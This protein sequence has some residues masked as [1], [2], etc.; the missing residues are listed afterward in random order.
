MAYRYADTLERIREQTERYNR[1]DGSVRLIAVS[2]QH[3]AE[4]VAAVARLGQTDFGENYVQES[5]AKIRA[6]AAML[7]SDSSP[8]PLVWHFIGHI[9]SRKCRDIAETFDWVHTIDSEKVARRLDTYRADKAPL[10]SLIQVNLQDEPGKSGISADRIGDLAALVDSLP[11]LELRGLMAI[12]RP[13]TEFSLQRD[14]FRQMRELLEHHRCRHGRMD[15][16]SMGMSDDME[17][18]ISEGATLIRVGTA[19][20]GPRTINQST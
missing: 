2:K 13:Q 8:L 15:Q 17:A 12:P 7:G 20:F 18:A 1:P 9:Q 16:L 11:N 10:Q 4:A 3:S 6:V 5:L 19:V 14:V